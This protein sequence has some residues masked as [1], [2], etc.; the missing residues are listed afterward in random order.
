MK[1]TDPEVKRLL[2]RA[3]SVDLDERVY[4]FPEEE[5]GIQTD[6]DIFIDELAYLIDLYDSDGTIFSEDLETARGIMKATDNG[7]VMPLYP[8]SLLPRY[9]KYEVD[10]ARDTINE[11]RRLK[12]LLKEVLS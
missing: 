5:R 6:M 9:R 8:D 7:K 3:N 10:N 12:R 2:K 4:S 11:Y 1:I